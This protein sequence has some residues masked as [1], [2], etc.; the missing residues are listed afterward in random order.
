MPEN[1]TIYVNQGYQLFKDNKKI[2]YGDYFLIG[3]V[4]ECINPPPHLQNYK[5]QDKELIM[6]RPRYDTVTDT[7]LGLYETLGYIMFRGDPQEHFLDY[8][9]SKQNSQI[10]DSHYKT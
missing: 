4:K 7:F 6:Y 2:Y 5:D 8:G 10:L 9:N 1:P 3:Q